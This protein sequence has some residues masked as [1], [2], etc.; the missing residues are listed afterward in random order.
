MAL[1]GGVDT[2]YTLTLGSP[3]DVRAEVRERIRVLGRDGGYICS[4]DQSIPM[5]EANTQAFEAAVLEFGRY[6]I[7]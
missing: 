6:P 7:G 4:P 5:P 1:H 2:Q 3:A